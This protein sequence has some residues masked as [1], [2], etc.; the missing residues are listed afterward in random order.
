M[1]GNIL[2]VKGKEINREFVSSG[3]R[4]Q[5]MDFQKLGK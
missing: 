1:N 4:T 5:K 2:V 3:E